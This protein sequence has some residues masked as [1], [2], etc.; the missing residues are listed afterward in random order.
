VKKAELPQDI[1]GVEEITRN[2]FLYME[3]K[4][5]K[6]KDQFA[7][8]SRCMMWTGPDRKTCTI[9]GKNVQ[10]TG[11]MSCAI[12]VQ[13]DPMPEQA[14]HE[15]ESVNPEESGL[16]RT[17][18]RC[19]NCVYF[20]PK[21][22]NECNFFH[23]LNKKLPKVFDLK[24]K[25]SPKGC[26]NA[27]I[28]IPDQEDIRKAADKGTVHQ[29]NDGHKYKKTSDKHWSPVMGK[30]G[31]GLKD[32]NSK[33]HKTLDDHYD[34]VTKVKGHMDRAKGREFLKE[35]VMGVVKDV[36]SKF[37]FYNGEMPKKMKEYLENYGESEKK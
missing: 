34:K 13:G 16:V 31:F 35:E 30:H 25:V 12:Y 10:V 17:A 11:D 22:N 27:F 5:E 19:E 37:Y 3:P 2:A 18:V 4:E 28:P 6:N 20:K 14:G 1:P 15:V 7:Q 24:E 21:T 29:Y 26:C 32:Q 33:S 9:H 36:L 8:C 23:Q